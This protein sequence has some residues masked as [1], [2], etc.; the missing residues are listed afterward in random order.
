MQNHACCHRAGHIGGRHTDFAEN[1][2]GDKGTNR[3][4]CAFAQAHVDGFAVAVSIGD[5]TRNQQNNQRGRHHQKQHPQTLCQCNFLL[6]PA[7][8]SPENHHRCQSARR[9]R[10]QGGCR[11]K[12]GDLAVK[13]GDDHGDHRDIKQNSNHA[14]GPAGRLIKGIGR[15][16]C[17]KKNPDHAQN[18]RP[19]LHGNTHR[20][21]Q[22]ACNK[23]CEHRSHH[24]CQWHIDGMGD[25]P[26]NK[27]DPK[28]DGQFFKEAR[29][30]NTGKSCDPT[31]L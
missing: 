23:G 7:G 13:P 8:R 21:A 1:Q 22:K 2:D 10:K 14:D 17:A 15:K 29:C 18:H 6:I 3:G 27:S 30:Q 5:D 9:C 12:T 28:A 20:H 19:E 26:A 31:V 16:G 24:P 11:I 25:E 4:K